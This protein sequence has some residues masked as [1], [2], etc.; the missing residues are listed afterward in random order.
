MRRT[1]ARLTAKNLNLTMLELLKALADAGPASAGDTSEEFLARQTADSRVWPDDDMVRASLL[2]AP[3][4]SAFLRAR[5]RMFLEV[6]EDDLRSDYGEGQPAPRGMTVEHLLPQSWGENWPLSGR[7]PSEGAER[8]RLVHRLGNL[9]LVSGKLNPA[10]SNR[11]WVNAN[12]PGKRDYLL[13][14][15]NLK[16]NA[17]VVAAHPTAWTSADIRARTAHLTER[18]LS[19]WSRPAPA[20]PLTASAAAM[21]VDATVNAEPEQSDDELV[22][23]SHTGK[24]RELW[25]WLSAQTAEEVSLAFTQIEQILG[26][27]LPPSSRL[28]RSHWFGF[29]NSA[30]A[31]AI[32]DAGYRTKA[33]DLATESVVLVPRDQDAGGA[34]VQAATDRGVSG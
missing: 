33:V 4:Y 29:D 15:S 16:L 19:A 8:D 7:D 32:H 14:H 21:A 6:L 24:Y 20:G 10:L 9:T 26:F 25:R 31:R 22:E 27:P 34:A 17:A 3:A 12:K 11:A 13:E 28:H 23:E 1:L 5:L 30:V 18:L 2:K